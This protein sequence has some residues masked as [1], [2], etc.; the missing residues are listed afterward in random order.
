MRELFQWSC[1]E[2]TLLNITLGHFE[3]TA[4][5]RSK[6]NRPA[7]GAPRRVQLWAATQHAP[8][9]VVVIKTHP[10][11]QIFFKGHVLDEPVAWQLGLDAAEI[12]TGNN[13]IHWVTQDRE[14]F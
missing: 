6:R 10:A 9:V 3:M 1:D 12:E 11:I 8:L 5:H 2:E 7:L 14:K 4:S 13:P